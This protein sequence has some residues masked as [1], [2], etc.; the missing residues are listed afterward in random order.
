LDSFLKISISAISK[1]KP[2]EIFSGGHSCGENAS[3]VRKI[4]GAGKSACIY[5]DIFRPVAIGPHWL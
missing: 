4:V 1:N 2:L 5:S 3:A